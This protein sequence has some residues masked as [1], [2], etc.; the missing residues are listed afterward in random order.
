MAQRIDLPIEFQF[1]ITP[2]KYVRGSIRL[3]KW[4]WVRL[5][6]WKLRAVISTPEDLAGF[7]GSNDLY[8]VR[9][10]KLPSAIQDQ[11]GERGKPLLAAVKNL[12][13]DVLLCDFPAGCDLE[14]PGKARNTDPWQLRHDFLQVKASGQPLLNFLNEY[15]QWS[16][17][18]YPRYQTTSFYDPRTREGNAHTCVPSLVFESEILTEQSA[19][20]TAL[21][22]SPGEWLAKYDLSLTPQSKFPHYVH[23]DSTCLGAIRTSVSIDFLR[24]VRFRICKR[25]DCG[26]PF[27][28]DRKGKQYCSQYCGHLVSVRRTRKQA[29]KRSLEGGK[30]VTV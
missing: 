13:I 14:H 2:V 20:R 29:K 25:P 27:P 17:V 3:L 8:L 1:K 7:G 16:G 28:A 5:D 30:D 9:P 18:T 12:D 4:S 23:A 11:L 6:G 19:I 21:Q 22:G 26:E 24:R 15:G 10:W